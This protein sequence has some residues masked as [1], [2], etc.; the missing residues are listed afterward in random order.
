MTDDAFQLSAHDVRH[1]EFHR[2]LRGYDATQVDDFKER[3]AQ[4]SR[5]V[6]SVPPAEG[7]TEVLLPGELEWREER[8]RRADGIPLYDEDWTALVQ[9]LARAGLPAEELA[10]RY[11]PEAG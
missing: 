10:G 1:Q 3:I 4:V 9:G 7:F 5:E 2:G 8:R 6:H 11:A